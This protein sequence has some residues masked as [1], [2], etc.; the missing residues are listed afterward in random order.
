MD[1]FN[2]LVDDEKYSKIMSDLFEDTTVTVIEYKSKSTNAYTAPGNFYIFRNKYMKKTYDLMNAIIPLKFMTIPVIISGY[3]FLAG[4]I[5]KTKEMYQEDYKVLYNPVTKK[6]KLPFKNATVF[7]SSSF[8]DI[9]DNN[10]DEIKAILLHELG[11]NLQTV[12]AYLHNIINNLSKV[13]IGSYSMTYLIMWAYK[14]FINHKE[15]TGTYD[16]WYYWNKTPKDYETQTITDIQNIKDNSNNINVFYFLIAKLILLSLLA[17]IITTYIR[18]NMEI[19]A[20]EMAIKLGYGKFLY[21][22]LDKLYKH[23]LFLD[24]GSGM[25]KIKG[26]NILDLFFHISTIILKWLVHLSGIFKILEYPDPFTRLKYVKEKTENYDI[27][28]NN[29]D[30]TEHIDKRMFK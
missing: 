21:S 15:L 16:K 10:E 24:T 3:I 4:L 30:R 9:L 11:H 5:Q 14:Y 25:R 19:Q 2:I 8:K 23:E 29:I 27:S 7:I 12:Q 1:T 28:D 13:V 22:A 17:S 26:Y 20:D 6:F 18:R